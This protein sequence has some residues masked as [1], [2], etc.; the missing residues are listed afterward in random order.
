MHSLLMLVKHKRLMCACFQ[1]VKSRASKFAFQRRHS[2]QYVIER[3]E[4]KTK[5]SS[6]SRETVK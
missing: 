3:M 1:Y 2:N 5:N 4:L 6:K